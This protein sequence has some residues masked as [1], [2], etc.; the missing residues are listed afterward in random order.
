MTTLMLRQYPAIESEH[1]SLLRQLQT[2]PERVPK[3]R[4]R[5]ARGSEWFADAGV[6]V[7]RSGEVK[8]VADA[9]PFGPYRSGHSHADTL[10][11]VVR[12]GEQDVLIDPGTFTYTDA[13][14][15]DLFL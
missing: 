3:P 7:M 4:S 15:R 5:A 10:S 6:A 12:R 9:G 11:I 1:P 14:W 8:I 2:T 13:K